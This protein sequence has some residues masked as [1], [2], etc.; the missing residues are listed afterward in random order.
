MLNNG[1]SLAGNFQVTMTTELLSVFLTVRK[2][3]GAGFTAMEIGREFLQILNDI[4]QQ[5]S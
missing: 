4:Y 5:N 3:T 1:G 2:L